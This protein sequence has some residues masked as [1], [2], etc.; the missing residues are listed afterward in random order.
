MRE[1]LRFEREMKDLELEREVSSPKIGTPSRTPVIFIPGVMGSELVRGN[2][3]V[4]PTTDKATVM[5]L[6]LDENGRDAGDP[7]FPTRVMRRIPLKIG[8]TTAVYEES[9]LSSEARVMW[10]ALTFLNFHTTGEMI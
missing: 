3:T 4:W 2:T 6:E 5:S 9:L 8:V 10:R 1:R 7:V